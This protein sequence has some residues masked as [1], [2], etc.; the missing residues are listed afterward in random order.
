MEQQDNSVATKPL[1]RDI[2]KHH[3]E[4]QNPP[5]DRA[6]QQPLD[7]HQE[8]VTSLQ[9]EISTDS[10]F[11][12]QH[13]VCVTS[14]VGAQLQLLYA[15]EQPETPLSSDIF[16]EHLHAKMMQ[17]ADHSIDSQTVGMNMNEAIKLE[18]VKVNAY[19]NISKTLQAEPDFYRVTAD[20]K[21]PKT[22]KQLKAEKL[23]Y[24][25][26]NMLVQLKKQADQNAEQFYGEY[27]VLKK[28]RATLQQLEQQAIHY[29]VYLE[30]QKTKI[31]Q[32]QIVL[33]Q[34]KA[35]MKRRH[36][37]L[38]QLEVS[39]EE[40]LELDGSELESEEA[41]TPEHE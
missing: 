11:E 41:T 31:I 14:N 10:H 12:S 4:N 23:L 8:A 19:M 18:E 24:K 13:T 35:E 5:A 7:I 26:L 37:L 17:N 39:H 9:I 30:Q 15:L 27:E 33:D 40:D 36:A 32:N 25:T 29:Q 22:E 38:E 2:L 3:L 34:Q 21:M 1:L 16:V 28:Q 20:I 6:E